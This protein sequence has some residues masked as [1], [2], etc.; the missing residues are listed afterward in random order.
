MF[1][2]LVG[3]AA[4]LGSLLRLGAALLP[5]WMWA[6]RALA[7]SQYSLYKERFFCQ[8]LGDF[9]IV[10]LLGLVVLKNNFYFSA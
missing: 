7:R 2:V 9:R 4:T 8:I 6:H 10:I 1:S 5:V 3:D